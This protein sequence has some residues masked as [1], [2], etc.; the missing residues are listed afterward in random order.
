MELKAAIE[1]Q[2]SIRKFKED[3][4]PGETIVE[5]LESARQAPSGTNLQPWRFMAVTSQEKRERLA[6]CTYNVNFIAQAPLIMVCC[7]DKSSVDTKGQRVKE[8]RE[9][10]AFAGTDLEKMTGKDYAKKRPRDDAANLAYLSLNAAIAIEHMVL[11]AVDLG[12][13][14]CWVMLFSQR[15]VKELLELPESLHV[16]ALLPVGYPAQDPKPRPRLAID[17]IYLGE[18]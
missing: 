1:K 7:V 14:S 9:S 6:K 8:L 4:L 17:E 12:L 13:G 18:V 3:K 10:G 15:R 16:V 2:R 5:L 11:R